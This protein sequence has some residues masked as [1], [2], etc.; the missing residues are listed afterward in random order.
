MLWSGGGVMAPMKNG[1]PY[2]QQALLWIVALPRL[3][4]LEDG[5]LSA[6]LGLPVM[7]RGG[8]LE[9][10]ETYCVGE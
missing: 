9:E 4:F 8:V 10:E 5:F 6:P 3:N 1:V 2:Y 7:S